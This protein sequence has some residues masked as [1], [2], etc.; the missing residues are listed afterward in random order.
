MYNQ[1]TLLIMNHGYNL[2]VSPF[3]IFQARF[4]EFG[5]V[6]LSTYT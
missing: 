3:N 4:K 2:T 5:D 6:D 1:L